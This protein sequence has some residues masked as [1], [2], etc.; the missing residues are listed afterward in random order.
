MSTEVRPDLPHDFL[1]NFRHAVV[2]TGVP[3][4]LFE[5]FF[6]GFGRE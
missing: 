5:D 4:D 2:L 1:R 3:G 6:L